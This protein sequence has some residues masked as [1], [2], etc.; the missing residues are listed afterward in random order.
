[1]VKCEIYSFPAEIPSQRS[2]QPL[3]QSIRRR[4]GR[5]VHR[6]NCAFKSY[7]IARRQR[8][9]QAASLIYTDEIKAHLHSSHTTPDSCRIFFV[10][11]LLLYMVVLAGAHD[12][13]IR[14]HFTLAHFIADELYELHNL[15][16]VVDLLVGRW[17]VRHAK[18][19]IKPYVE[20]LFSSNVQS[21]TSHGE[22]ATLLKV[23]N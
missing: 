12:G 15:T 5:R 17:L 9:P 1:M 19:N 6:V 8:R 11:L 14:T 10:G 7:F 4:T 3:Q 18:W 23:A 16:Y 13:S 2:L 21:V 22:V 20:L